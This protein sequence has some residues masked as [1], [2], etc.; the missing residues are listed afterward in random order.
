M[1]VYIFSEVET[2]ASSSNPVN[3]EID[4]GDSIPL[5]TAT[6]STKKEKASIVSSAKYAESV[7]DSQQQLLLAAAKTELPVSPEGAQIKVT[8]ETQQGMNVEVVE[9]DQKE[10]PKKKGSKEVNTTAV[11][12]EPETNKMIEETE[13]NLN[14][15]ADGKLN[16]PK[17]TSPNVVVAVGKKQEPEKTSL[18]EVVVVDQKQGPTKNHPKE[19]NPSDVKQELEVISPIV[20]VEVGNEEAPKIIPIEIT[21]VKK[22]EGTDEK[23]PVEKA[24]M[25]KN[26]EPEKTRPINISAVNKKQELD[27]TR[28]IEKDAIERKEEP[29]KTIPIEISAIEK[30]EGP[31]KTSPIQAATVTKGGEPEKTRPIQAAAIDMKQDSKKIH[32]PKASAVEINQPQ[33]KSLDE[34]AVVE[35]EAEKTK[36]KK[37]TRFDAELQKEI[38]NLMEEAGAAI[39]REYNKKTNPDLNILEAMLAHAHQSLLFED[40]RKGI[41]DAIAYSVS[42]GEAKEK[43]EEACNKNG[44]FNKGESKDDDDNAHNESDL[45]DEYEIDDHDEDE[46]YAENECYNKRNADTF[47]ECYVENETDNRRNAD[48]FGESCV[49]NETDNRRN[50]DTFGEAYVENEFDNKRNAATFG[51]AFIQKHQAVQPKYQA[52]PHNQKD[53]ESSRNEVLHEFL[54]FHTL[55]RRL[56]W[57]D[58]FNFSKYLNTLNEN[59]DPHCPLAKHY[60]L[61]SFER[62]MYSSPIF[63]E[64]MRN[65]A[66]LE[67]F[68]QEYNFASET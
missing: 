9:G 66:P 62:I 13:K 36:V 26:E 45:A 33:E 19:V 6:E 61:E 27:E 23:S 7:L 14:E 52:I 8:G 42:Y 64:S 21:A 25:N 63:L 44:A 68:D 56:A 32:L 11:K 40:P 59:L 50:A 51:E 60:T 31:D 43:Q 39:T 53:I 48:T 55:M 38:H 54:T 67:Q 10:E 29:E 3:S 47:G 24:A 41:E 20:Q 5:T 28:P 35:L 58:P 22:K 18:I 30:K 65:R 37:A 46:A 57:C 2:M 16:E 12:Q 17:V 34:Q 1:F 49:E 4:K 15:V